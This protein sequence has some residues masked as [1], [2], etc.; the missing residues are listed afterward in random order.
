[1]GECLVFLD[2]C[3]M[4]LLFI[5]MAPFM[6]FRMMI[7]ILVSILQI[8]VLNKKHFIPNRSHCAFIC[9]L[10]RMRWSAHNTGMLWPDSMS[11][12]SLYSVVREYGLI[13]RSF[14]CVVSPVSVQRMTYRLIRHRIVFK[15]K[16]R[17]DNLICP[18][19]D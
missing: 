12:Y 8:L 7:I 4:A 6:S 10:C 17:F 3:P 5:R 15:D 16:H 18:H 2:H 1:M 9:N 14:M 11:L 13:I 19:L